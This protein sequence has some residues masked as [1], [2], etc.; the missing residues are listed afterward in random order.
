MAQPSVLLLRTAG[1]NCDEETRFAFERAGATVQPVHVRALCE[2][3][4]MLSEHRILVFSGGFSYGDDLGSGV[5]LAN[6]LT[7]RL[8]EPLL[9]HIERG[10]LTIGI[11]NG[12]QVLV[13]T[14]LLPG[15]SYCGV[16]VAAAD[17]SKIHGST[18]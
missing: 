10:G 4:G 11:C 2:R 1:T 8:M 17:Q 9:C 18:G 3:P 6:E 13:K 14:G 15:L 12:F 7:Q 16:A 5:V